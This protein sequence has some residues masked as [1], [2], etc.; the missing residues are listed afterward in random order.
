MSEKRRNL[1]ILG[2]VVLLAVASAAV[3]AVRGF[4]LGLDLR[5]GLEVVLKAQPKPGQTVTPSIL[6]DAA[7]VMRA[8]IDPNGTL[9]PDIRTSTSDNTIEIQV[10]GVKN[11][12]AVSDLLTA[13]QLQD[14]NFFRWLAPVSYS[15]G[16]PFNVVVHNSSYALLK[17]AQ[18]QVKPGSKPTAWG[19]YDTVTHKPYR[20]SQLLPR[21]SQ[22]LGQVGL[23]AGSPLPP[24]VEWLAVPQGT[25]A[26]SCDAATVGCY[27]APATV[28]AGTF[29]YLFRTPPS[30][31]L[32]GGNDITG[33]SSTTD[34]NG[35]PI[36][37]LSY[38]NEGA[39]KFQRITAD[40]VNMWQAAPSA[41]Q[42]AQAFSTGLPTAIVVNSQLVSNP[43][44]DPHTFPGGIDI[45]LNNQSQITG[46]SV[47]EANR[48]ALEVQSGT[49]PVTFSTESENIVSATL[50]KSSL[51]DAL[52]A[53]IAGLAFVLVFLVVFYGFLGLVAD[54]ALLVYGLLLAAIVVLLPVTMTLPGIAGTILTIGVAADANI[55]IFERIKEEMRA[56]K[57][58]RAAISTGYRRGW[59]TIIDANVVTLITAAILYVSTTASVKGFALMLL[60]GVITSIF[61]AVVATRAMLG[62]LSGFA[63]MRSPR[64]MGAV[65]SGDR[66][67]R[68]DFIGRKR[69]WFAF[70]LVVL[71]AGALSLGTSGL[72]QGIDFTGGSR[73]AYDTQT[74]ASQ[75]QM[76]SLVTGVLGGQPQVQGLVKPGQPQGSTY[77]RWQV[78]AHYLSAKGQRQLLQRLEAPPPAGYGAQ[79]I[80]LSNVSSSFGR[81]V[82]D[83]AILAVVF[84]LIVISLYVTYRFEWRFAVPVLIALFHDVLV[85]VGVYSI[86]GRQVT[87]DTVAAV[88]TV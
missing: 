22:V 76:Q 60:I 35:N 46:V 14:F 57:S 43:T 26:V 52:V 11:P 5:G 24:R 16:S 33:A 66:W 55:V 75:G 70:S 74:A 28:T 79:G 87:A 25:F 44:V 72:N 18:K 56:G 8:R 73:I 77:K 39:T 9:Q 29:W 7:N 59:H 23:R 3:V 61:T 42:A 20:H 21:K 1:A 88:L 37:Q 71:V 82:L 10:P 50:G 80:S 67:K 41:V 81:A 13:G 40:T 32:I 48:I 31:Q 53:G 38:T 68:I 49:L 45:S 58:L 54:L 17:A 69:W 34:Q 63:F 6:A 47:S 78:Q 27:G 64:V 85:T 86:T 15:G 83:N 19:L 65:G 51:H 84:S 2:V 30:G 36:V 62:V 12:N 4:T